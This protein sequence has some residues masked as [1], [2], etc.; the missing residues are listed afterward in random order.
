METYSMETSRNLDPHKGEINF[1]GKVFKYKTAPRKL[2]HKWLD[3]E[4]TN[5]KGETI[6][7]YF[8]P[9]RQHLKKEIKK[10]VRFHKWI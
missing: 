2:P 9:R 1:D 5:A 6:K 8:N 7:V 10:Q 3:L 4:I